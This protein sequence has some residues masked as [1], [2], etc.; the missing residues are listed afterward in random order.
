M[1]TL[2]EA[3]FGGFISKVIN[4]VGDVTKEKIIAA[5]K[6][7]NSKHQNLE[8][9]IYNIIVSVLNKITYNQYEDEQDKIYDVAEKLLKYFKENDSDY[10]VNLKNRLQISCSDED[11]NKC[12]EFKTLL[13]EELGKEEHSELFRAILLL[14]LGIVQK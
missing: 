3:V 6:N 8:S 9:Q 13:Y 1:I 4:D 5:V 14:V 2:M 10:Q 11:G 12:K 7:K